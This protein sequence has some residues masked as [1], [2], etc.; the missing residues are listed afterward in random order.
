MLKTDR[1]TFNCDVNGK[2]KE[3][4]QEILYYSA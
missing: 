4:I 2:V 1:Y 3:L